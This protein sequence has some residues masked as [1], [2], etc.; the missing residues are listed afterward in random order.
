MTTI[1]GIAAFLLLLIGAVLSPWDPWRAP[2][3]RDGLVLTPAETTAGIPD[4]RSRN[5]RIWVAERTPGL[6]AYFVELGGSVPLERLGG[7]LRIVVLSGR[8]RVRAGGRECVVG[9]GGYL[10]IPARLP[11]RIL[12]E[13]R[14]RLLY[15]AFFSPDSP[16]RTMMEGTGLLR[17]LEAASR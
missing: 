17:R 14:E 13:G 3:A 2:A 6:G 11:H 1:L 5:A 12:R 10:G 16:N 4:A 8:M 9:E 15:A 7:R